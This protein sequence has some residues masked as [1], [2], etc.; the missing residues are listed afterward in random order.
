MLSS[1]QVEEK[2]RKCADDDIGL[3]SVELGLGD[4]HGGG[5]ITVA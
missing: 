1:E 2:C 4:P 3:V 5:E